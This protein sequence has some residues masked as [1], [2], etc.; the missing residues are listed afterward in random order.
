[1]LLTGASGSR[2]AASATAN[3]NEYRITKT[4]AI[5]GDGRWDLLAIDPAARRIYVPRS[6]HTQ[7]INAQT[8]KVVG[9]LTQTPGV[10]GVAVVPDV[11]R[12]FTSNGRENSVTIFDLK[13]LQV[14]GTTPA[15]QNPDAI[16]YDPASHRVVVLNGRS[17]DATL[18]DPA[19]APGIAPRD[20]ARRQT[21]AG[22][23]RR[24]RTRLRQ[25]RRQE[26]RRRRGY[27]RDEG[28]EHLANRGR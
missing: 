9:D 11:N 21:R 28:H 12:G 8:G 15:G 19:A 4:L 14:I 7:V 17:D 10:H 5:G 2:C 3:E 27:Q 6:T 18:I 16:I 24:T 20:S 1:M 13:S 23:R 25:S 22:R 26:R